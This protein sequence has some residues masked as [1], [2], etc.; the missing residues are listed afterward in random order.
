MTSFTLFCEMACQ[1]FQKKQ[2]EKQLE[3]E[4]AAKAQN[5]KLPVCYDDDDD[6]ERS[7]YLEDNIIISGLPPCSAITPNEPVLSTEEPDN[8]LS[9][10][11]E[12][13]DT[14]LAMESDEF[15]KS[16]V[17]NLIPIPSESEEFSSIDDDCF[18]IDKI[19][20]VEASPP[21]SELVSL[22]VMEIVIP[23]VGGIDDDILLTIKD[24]ILHENLLNVNHLFTKIEALNDNPTPL[25][26]PIVSGTPPTLTPSGESDFFFEETKSFSTSLNSLLEETNNFDNSLPKFTTFSNVLFDAEYEFDASDDQSF[27]DK[28]VPEKIFST[29]LFNEEIIPMKIDPH[30]DNAK[31]DLMESLR[32]HDSS[33][34]I[35]SKIDSLLDEFAGELTLLKSIPPGIDETDCDFE[36]DIRLIERLLYDNSS[37]CPSKEFVSSNSDA[38]I[39]SFSPSP[40]LVKDSDT[41]MEEIDFTFTPDYPM[42]PGIEDDEYD[43]ERDILILK[44]L[45][46]NNTLSFA[47]KESFHFDI[48]SFSRPPA[49]TTRW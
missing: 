6:E 45:P 48:P 11:D 38:G 36:E 39:E 23:K 20:Y 43:S 34:S 27:S 9:M 26:D 15:I 14:I 25:Y 44:D 28:D 30:P 16:S 40:I 47:K 24:D 10:G 33:L 13:L 31:S 7:N 37:P 19:D 8:S 35:S 21:D 12:H 17:E 4:Q 46:S 2:E 18:S 22:E 41:L 32:I 42:P 1:I 29:L 3:E 49:K 5:W